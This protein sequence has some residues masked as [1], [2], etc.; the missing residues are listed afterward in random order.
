MAFTF[1]PTTNLGKVRFLI[2]DMT[3]SGHVFEDATINAAISF[4]SSDLYAA[5][6]LCLYSL[7]ASKALLAKRKAAGKYSEDLTAIAKECRETAKAY[8]EK[9][10]SIPSEAQAEQFLTDFNYNQI[11]QNKAL[12]DESD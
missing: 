10:R 6:A 7:S 1:D 5:A 4:T 12:R 11:L 8:E 9:S 3:D 2:G